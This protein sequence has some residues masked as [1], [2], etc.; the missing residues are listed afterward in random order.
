MSEFAKIENGAVVQVIIAE[1]L[2][3]GS[4]PGEWVDVTNIAGV[5]IGWAY[6]GS[7]FSPP[8]VVPTYRTLLTQ[9]EWASTWTPAEWRQLKR[10]ASGALSPSPV[11]NNVSERLDQLL[12]SIRLT[13]AFDVAGATADQFYAYLVAQGFITQARADVLQAGV[14]E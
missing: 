3:I 1:P 6:S 7:T 2:D 14:L 11:S 10:A 13:N 9:S 5:G 8:V 4:I 12:D